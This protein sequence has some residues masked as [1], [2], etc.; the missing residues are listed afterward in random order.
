MMLVF[1][2]GAPLMLR[3]ACDRSRL[4]QAGG[5]YRER[6][7]RR[8]VER[9]TAKNPEKDADPLRLDRVKMRGKGGEGREP[10]WRTPP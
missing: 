2:P 6:G 5:T 7:N 3:Q 4:L 10:G 1:G 8:Q 9:R